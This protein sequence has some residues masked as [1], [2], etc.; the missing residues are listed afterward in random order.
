MSKRKTTS[1][2]EKLDI[3]VDFFLENRE[4]YSGKEL[5]KKLPK[6][7]NAI[8]FPLIKDLLTQLT[9]DS[10]LDSDK[11]GSS[12]HYWLFP[13]AASESRKRKKTEIETQIEAERTKKVKIE[14]EIAEASIGKEETEERSALLNE[15]DE[16]KK[17]RAE[18]MSQLKRFQDLDPELIEKIKADVSVCKDAANRWT[19]NVFS[20]MSYCKN[21][22]N[23]DSAR[24][25]GMFD[26][27]EDFDNIE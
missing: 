22:L 13:S 10:R 25:N 15:L 6:Y 4:P 24:I 2:E 18:V 5:E 23:M 14:E 8:K 11:I 21:K 9:A 1:A 27:P 12:N 26:I 17:E 19:D 20:L 3:V 16:I 7:N